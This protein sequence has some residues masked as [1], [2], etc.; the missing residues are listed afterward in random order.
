M[1]RKYEKQVQ[2]GVKLLDFEIPNWRMGIDIETLDMDQLSECILGQLYGN[3]FDG[4]ELLCP[5]TF[6]FGGNLWARRRGFLG[7]LFFVSYGDY[8]ALREEWIRQIKGE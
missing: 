1:K 7:P 8:E 6:P 4:L 5:F 3:Y 2:R